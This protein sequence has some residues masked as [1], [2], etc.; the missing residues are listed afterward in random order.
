[1]FLLLRLMS[2]LPKAAATFACIALLAGVVGVVGWIHLQPGFVIGV[3]EQTAPLDAEQLYARVRFPLAAASAPVIVSG[4][5]GALA[6]GDWLFADGNVE[7]I[8]GRP[9]MRA[10]SFAHIPLNAV[11]TV[12]THD[13][14][15]RLAASPTISVLAGC[16][17]LIAG[18]LI[19]AGTTAVVFAG[20]GAC[21]AWHLTLA[22]SFESWATVPPFGLLAL[23]VVGGIIGATL[24]WRGGRNLGSIWQRLVAAAAI[25]FFLP[26]L[27]PLFAWPDVASWLLLISALA[28]PMIASAVVGGT[29]LVVGLH[30]QGTSALIVLALSG[31]AAFIAQAG[32]AQSRRGRRHARLEPGRFTAAVP[33]SQLLGHRT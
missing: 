20:I 24:G 4:Q 26:V 21:L 1:M 22:A 10:T 16:L 3:V 12:Q 25:Y 31:V 11:W 17:V 15:A 18:G 27:G 2:R 6:A 9:I 5:Q 32:Q 33:L 8:G 29:L 28:L 19:V 14:G 7:D 13:L 30:A 23:V